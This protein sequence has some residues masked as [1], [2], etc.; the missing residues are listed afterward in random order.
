MRCTSAPKLGT[1]H[2]TDI[3][4]VS[5]QL[6]VLLLTID[7]NICMYKQLWKN[8]DLY[9]IPF[10]V[11]PQN[12]NRSHTAKYTNASLLK[13]PLRPL[14]RP[15]MKCTEGLYKWWGGMNSLNR[16]PVYKQY[17]YFAYTLIKEGGGVNR[18]HMKHKHRGPQYWGRGYTIRGD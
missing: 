2:T 8:R 14:S 5:P 13:E 9:L 10:I 4:T 12:L 7:I 1:V 16:F 17:P 18:V 15:V 6:L 11:L 3:G